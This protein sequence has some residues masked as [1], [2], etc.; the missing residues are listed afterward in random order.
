MPPRVVD[1]ARET[2]ID[3]LIHR[4][5]HCFIPCRNARDNLAAC[6]VQNSLRVCDLHCNVR[7]RSR[8][9]RLCGFEHHRIH[10]VQFVRALRVERPERLH[11]IR[12]EDRRNI[13]TTRQKAL[14][15]RAPERRFSVTQAVQD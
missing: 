5:A 2:V 8:E 7:D 15:C 3:H 10:K 4:V 1:V 12:C 11:L 6:D 14:F 13:T 9:R